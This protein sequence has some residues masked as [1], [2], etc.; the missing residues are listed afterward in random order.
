[1]HCIV[2]LAV[3]VALITLAT[4]AATVLCAAEP[5]LAAL[6]NCAFYLGITLA[7][8]PPML[9]LFGLNRTF[10][11]FTSLN[12][13]V[14]VSFAAV[15]VV[16]LAIS[17]DFALNR[18]AGVPRLLP[19]MQVLLLLYMLAGARFAIR[20]RHERR[21]RARHSQAVHG[22]P[23]ENI[24]VIGL[25]PIADLFLS[26]AA[27][28]GRDRVEIVG[29]LSEADRHRGRVLRSRKILGP[30]E[31]IEDVLHEL[32]IHG[33]GVDRVVLASPLGQL[34]PK[35]REALQN[36]E[37]CARIRI[38]C[39]ATRYGMNGDASA[40]KIFVGGQFGVAAS[41][42]SPGGADVPSHRYLRW[43]RVLD[44][45]VAVT[46]V[47][48]FAPAMLFVFFVV[49]LDV[50]APAI[51]WQQRPGAGGR[52]IRVWKFR[53]MGPARG[54][55][56]RSLSD[57]ER[58]SSIGHLLRRL[59]L[60]ELPQVFNILLGHMSLVGPRPLL[61]IDQPS[62]PGERLRL[63][64]GLTGWAQ[65]NGGRHLSIADKAALDIWYIKNASFGLDMMILAH[66]ARTVLFGEKID[67][68][69][70]HEAWQGIQDEGRALLSEAPEHNQI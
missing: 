48:C 10:W 9:L 50:G 5:P 43:K 70:I 18:S 44:I 28:T 23:R 24:L 67:R 66:T 6:A 35:A 40:P 63:R 64:P 51:F 57:A 62:A 46:C 29:I 26:C 49:R 41:E 25:N 58:L 53:T 56:G 31:A 55:D 21:R 38:D 36:L 30:P 37:T 20:F 4:V 60:D 19:L 54:R 68:R 2:L 61:P 69:A 15:A 34:S 12:D 22:G 52:P 59:R 14:R 27:E 65:I 7:V 32:S 11:R 8:T 16:T 42:V 39:L 33:V 45:L 1:M 17:I 3:D 13:A 47:V